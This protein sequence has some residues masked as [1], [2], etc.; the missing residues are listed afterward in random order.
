M[1][2]YI[3][4]L[5]VRR[6]LRMFF[7]IVV[8]NFFG[9]VVL[10][11]ALATKT[12]SLIYMGCLLCIIPY[13]LSTIVFVLTLTDKK[14]WGWKKYWDITTILAF[15]PLINVV[16]LYFVAIINMK[17]RKEIKSFSKFANQ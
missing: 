8:L 9:F 14:D 13:F 2:D 10:F 15:I 17:I 12:N 4:K 3:L 16:S 7:W 11:S 5:K 1:E 6:N